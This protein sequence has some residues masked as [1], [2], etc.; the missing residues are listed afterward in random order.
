MLGTSNFQYFQDVAKNTNV[1]NISRITENAGDLVVHNSIFPEVL[2][3]IEQICIKIN[4]NLALL[5]S[6]GWSYIDVR[7]YLNRIFAAWV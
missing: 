7:D 6:S 4:S 5:S 2:F 3:N 1:L